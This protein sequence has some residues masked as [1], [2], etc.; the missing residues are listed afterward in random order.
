MPSSNFNSDTLG[1]GS[2]VVTLV[3]GG[4]ELTIA[5]SYH[6]STG[7]L[8]QPS[9]FSFTLG[10]GTILPKDILA[11]AVPNTAFQLAVG[12]ILQFTGFLDGANVSQSADGPTQVS[13]RGRDALA[14]LHDSFVEVENAYTSTSYIQFVQTAL[15]TVGFKGKL[16]TN[17]TASRSARAG[18][19]VLPVNEFDSATGQAQIIA[20][21]GAPFRPLMAKVKERWGH[22]VKREL[23]RAGLMLWSDQVG[24]AVL[25]RPNT[26]QKPIYRIVR[27]RTGSRANAT[28]VTFRNE[29]T[30]RFSSC[31]VYGH[32]GGKKNGRSHAKGEYVDDEMTGWG[33]SRPYVFQNIHLVND[34]QAEYLA[35]RK[36]AESRRQGW[37]LS[38]VLGGHTTPSIGSTGRAV[39]TPD[40]MIDVDD[41]ELGIKGAFWLESVEYARS[42]ETTTTVNLMRVEDLL[43][44]ETQ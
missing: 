42:P 3:L 38:Y 6:V 9:A 35:S 7:I 28:S 20:D 43:F 13:I 16:L 32:F 12:G 24:N 2:D 36:L 23:D 37:H 22:I 11:T 15:D 39:W 30:Q 21:S 8:D 33:Y 17:Y 19:Q 29:S 44:G 40:T 34:K 5:E 10:H 1:A 25:S 27:S 26:Y 41:E 14:V 4:K 18:V 31:Q